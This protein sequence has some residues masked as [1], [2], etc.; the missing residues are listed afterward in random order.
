MDVAIW[1]LILFMRFAWGRQLC[2]NDGLWVELRGNSWPVRTWY[3]GYS[4]TTLLHGGILGPGCAGGQGIDT[5]TEEHE[6]VHVEQAEA[7]MLAGLLFGLYP[8][9]MAA[10]GESSMGTAIATGCS[11]WLSSW[12]VYYIAASITAVLR[13]EKAY[14]GNHL[15]EAAYNIKPNDS[16]PE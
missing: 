5:D 13:G 10:L 11:I 4:G 3:K 2:W 9:L 14:R 7:A 6:S 16:P 8:V 12:P 1:I 15:E